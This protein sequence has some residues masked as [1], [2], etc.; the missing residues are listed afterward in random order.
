MAGYTRKDTTNNIATGNIINASDLDL[1]YDGIQTAFNSTS[2]HSHNGDA[3]EGAP[4]LNVG[5]S[6]DVVVSGSSILPKTDNL[7][8]LGSNAKQFK[9]L[10][11]NGVANIDSLVA[12]TVAI[13]AGTI[14]GITDLAVADG[15]TGSSTAAGARTNLGATTVGGNLFTLANPSA[16]TFPRLNADNSVSTLSA[17]DFRTAIGATSGTGTVTSVAALTLGTSGTD[18]SSTVADGTTTPTIT[19]NVPTASAANRG[20]L[21]STDWTTFNNKTSNT[22]T[23]TSITAGTGLSGGTITS[24]GTVA[25]ANTAVT[26]GSYT[27]ADITVDA[28]GRITAAANGT[29]GGTGTVTSVAA[30]VPSLLSISGS[31]I[32]TSGTLAISYS[33]TALPIANGGTGATSASAAR[34]SLGA[35]TL[36]GNLFTVTNPSAITF[37]RFNANNTISSLSAA[38]FRTAI[39]VGTGGG[40]VTSVSGTGTV[41]GL[42]LSGTVTTSGN[43]T[44]SGTLS[45]TASGLTVGTATDA[46]SVALTTSNTSSAFKVPFANT[47]ASTNG[48]YGLLQDSTATFTYNPNTNTLTAGTFS[49]T[50]TVATDVTVTTSATSSNFKIPFANTTVSTTGSYG[51]LQDSAATFTYNPST[52]T[53]TA[54]TFAGNATSVTDGVYTTGDQTIGGVKTFTSEIKTNSVA[55]QSGTNLVLNGIVT[56]V[57]DGITSFALGPSVDNSYALGNASFRW[58]TVFATTGT[59]NTSD[60]NAKQDIAPLDDAEK[61][62]ALRIKAQI[63]KFRFK[64]AVVKKGNDARIHIGVIAQEVGDAFRAEGLDPNRYGIFCYDEWE[65]TPDTPAGSSYGVRYEELLAFMIAAL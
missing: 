63:K 46:T 51:L 18:L 2:G 58:T 23:V 40:T 57:N 37:P 7:I 3:G 65:A 29:S 53:L 60:L 30:T 22:G 9:D 33:G 62:V 38:D 25:L 39:G 55:P 19:L 1:E 34:T 44:L 16:I 27:L 42:S 21:S 10:H 64:D 8:D 31:P 43:I 5:P 54:G 24:S 61:R 35:T 56:I 6:Q 26:A 17:A 49:G 20:V 47:T 32:T 50:A 28:Q 15:G 48:N 12:D 36:G 13:S 59:I 41:N 11:I 52:N 14:T 45:G 4:I